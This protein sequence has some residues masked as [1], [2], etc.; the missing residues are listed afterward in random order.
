LLGI[1]F[2]TILVVERLFFGVGLADRPALLL[3]ALMLVLGV[4]I[5]ALGLIG[6]LIIFTH[7]RD[8]KEYAVRRIVS[9]GTQPSGGETGLSRAAEKE[10]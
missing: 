1:V 8:L 7:A 6:E 10:S 9:A 3:S 5:F 4:Q 2:L